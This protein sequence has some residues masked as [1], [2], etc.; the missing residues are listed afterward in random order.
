MDGRDAAR[1]ASDKSRA[2]QGEQDSVDLRAAVDGPEQ[3]RPTEGEERRVGRSTHLASLACLARA[4]LLLS[5]SYTNVHAMQARPPA[6]PPGLDV[7]LLRL[8]GSTAL[9]SRLDAIVGPKTLILTPNLAGPLGLVTEVG[10]LKVR[11][12]AP[13]HLPLLLVLS[14][15]SIRTSR[16]GP[17]LTC[18]PSLQNNHAVTKMF[19]LEPGVLSQAERNI[20]Y[21]C[22][23]EVRWMRI[24]AGAPCLS[25]PDSLKHLA[26]ADT[27]L[28][29]ADQ[30]RT[31]PQA[32]QHNYHLL[33][34]P[35]MTTLCTTVLSDLGV[36]GSIEVQELQLGL[37]PL[38]KDVLSLEYEDTWKKT[39]LVRPSFSLFSLRSSIS[40]S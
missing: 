12:P 15:T 5:R 39:E 2:E 35:R 34:A 31:T 11:E 16:R 4:R 3:R 7:E 18:R 33:V 9:Q 29:L 13:P 25:L 21:V 1:G 38:E 19:W 26:Q 24:I 32:N 36:L 22:R 37:I 23:P 8:L 20:V 10:L 40:A 28:L 14:P 6:A 27:T 17:W 30:V